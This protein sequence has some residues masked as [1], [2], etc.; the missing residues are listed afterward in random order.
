MARIVTDRVPLGAA[1]RDLRRQ[2]G[3][4]S[5]TFYSYLLYGDVTARLGGA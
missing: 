1:L 3:G 5:P 4:V 2:H